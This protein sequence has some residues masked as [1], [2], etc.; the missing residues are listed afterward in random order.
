MQV[1]IDYQISLANLYT[2]MGVSLE[3]NQIEFIVPE[4]DDADIE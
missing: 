2:V 3:R 1:L 4:H